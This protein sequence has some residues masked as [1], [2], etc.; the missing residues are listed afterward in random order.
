[1]K[2]FKKQLVIASLAIVIASFIL[3]SPVE[4]ADYEEESVG[5]SL[6]VPP[7]VSITITDAG[8]SGVNFG[9]IDPGTTDVGDADQGAS[10]PAI[11]VTND[12]VSNFN[13]KVNVKGT[14]FSGTPSGTLTVDHVTYDDDNTP[15]EVSETGKAET[16]LDTTYP[17]TD[18][19]TGITPGSDADFWFFI[20]VPSDQYAADYSSTFTFYGGA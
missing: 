12:A 6:A 14:D 9:S 18:Y 13:I 4:S 5:A 19:Y 3:A 10:T 8:T 2:D 11:I 7:M 17:V 15:S 16:A 20:D 1:M